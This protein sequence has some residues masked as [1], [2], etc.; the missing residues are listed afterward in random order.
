MAS[1]TLRAW[2]EIGHG[3][4]SE[5]KASASTFIRSLMQY[6]R[7]KETRHRTCRQNDQS[8]VASLIQPCCGGRRQHPCVDGVGERMDP[9]T[10]GTV[11]AYGVG[12]RMDLATAGTVSD[13]AM[14][15]L[16]ADKALGQGHQNNHQRHS[17]N[18][19]VQRSRYA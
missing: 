8:D 17:N 19:R 10:V 12:E 14:V 18:P 4:F 1:Q 16:F 11:S 6:Q 15:L 13:V 3:H 7:E 5:G 2:R 9:A